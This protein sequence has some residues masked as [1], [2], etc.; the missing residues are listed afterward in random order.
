M[1]KRILIVEDEEDNRSLLID[2]IEG[3]LAQEVLIAEDG[4]E[5]ILMAHEHRP[6][7]ILMDLTL[8][9]MDGWQATRSLKSTEAFRNTPILAISAHAMVGDRERALEAGCDAHFAKPIDL[10]AFIEFLQPY[11]H[12]E[13][14]KA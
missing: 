3:M 1:P 7:L 13:G 9:K 6:D 11:L 14:A 4:L 12:E 5:A 8:P 10:D 2:I